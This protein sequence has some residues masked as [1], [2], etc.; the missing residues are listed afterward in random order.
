MPIQLSELA[1]P[2]G[3]DESRRLADFWKKHLDHIKDDQRHKR[4][5]KRGRTI[6]KRYRDERNR[7]DEEGQRRYNALWS[8]VEI[9]TPA[10][11]GKTP[12]PI[13]ERRF[14]DKDVVGRGAAQIL[15]RALR[16]EVEICGFDEAMQQVVRDYLLPGRGTLW[17]RYEP[18]LEESVSLVTEGGLD[19]HDTQGDIEPDFA[20]EN[21]EVEKLE[22]TGDRIT[23]ESTPVDYINW[24]DFFTIPFN[25]RTW[26]EVTAV[27]KRVYNTRDQ[28]KR[29]FNREIAMGVPLKKDDRQT[30]KYDS[31][32]QDPDDKAVVYEIWSLVDKAVF[33]VAEGYEFLLDRQDDPLGLESF[34]PCPRPLYANATTGTLVPVPDYLEYQDQAIQIDELTQRIAMLAKACKVAGVYNAQAKDIQRMFN[35]SVENELIPVDDW[36]AFGEQG[37]V[38]GNISLLPLKEIIGVLNELMMIKDKAI[39]EMDRLTG[40]NDIMRGT[41]DARETLGGQRLKSNS[42]GTRLQRRQNEVARFARDTVRIIADIMAQ[43]FSPQS[44]IDVSGALY[45]EGL[46]P[47]DM[48]GLAEMAQ[49]QFAPPVSPPGVQQGGAPGTPPPPPGAGA[50]PPAATGTNVVPLRPPGP[51][52]APGMMQPPPP[53]PEMMA[54]M[55]ALQRIGAA[56]QL[57]RN[58]RLRGF[59]VDIEVDSTIYGDSAQDKADRIEFLTA[60]TQFLQ[61]SLQMAGE[62][63]QI[64]P[65]LGKF[66]QFGVRG[67]H[68][69]RDLELA[70]EEFCDGAAG[71]AAQRAQQIANRPDPALI[72]SN[73]AMVEAQAR[74]KEVD[75]RAQNDAAKTQV[76]VHTA[77]IKAQSDAARSQAEIQRQAIENQGDAYQANADMRMKEIDIEM[78]RLELE[79]EKLKL[80][81]AHTHAT[82]PQVPPQEASMGNQEKK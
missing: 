63:P 49:N 53:S 58:E 51:P 40:I 26:K 64:T 78:R 38:A 1:G 41:T 15:E 43:H 22:Q 69:G 76:Q 77:S 66:L 56:L 57:I 25:A 61:Q 60:V 23:R 75:N 9:L 3:A 36:A 48:P 46:G 5:L 55:Q 31:P 30:V 2:N 50:P 65:L 10:I 82:A 32:D 71:F 54:K 12:T 42:T 16:N 24:E 70:I 11:Y 34:F 14:R 80:M 44:L 74:S 59:R 19:I 67:F 7:V 37:G 18:E 81:T 29:R 20:E 79:M 45:E 13:A 27:A 8:N 62:M 21:P 4:W 73:A 52:M 35:E 33:W 6:E 39:Q 68:I 47:Q 72:K 28:L 17:V